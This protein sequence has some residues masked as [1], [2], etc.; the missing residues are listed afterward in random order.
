[1]G[2]SD[3]KQKYYDNLEA[4]EK[5]E[6]RWSQLES[7]LRRLLSRLSFVGEG[8]SEKLDL[9]L[10]QLRNKVRSENLAPLQ[11]LIDGVVKLAESQSGDETG[12]DEAK[13]RQVMVGL[14]KQADFQKPFIKRSTA[15]NRRLA[16]ESFSVE[17][18]S[19]FGGL[20]IDHLKA[21]GES[22]DQPTSSVLGR[23][24]KKDVSEAA[25]VSESRPEAPSLENE[26]QA[27]DV[28]LFLLDSLSTSGIS[29]VELDLLRREVEGAKTRREFEQL[30]RQLGNLITP[31][32]GARPEPEEVLLKL[33]ETLELPADSQEE[34]SVLQ[35]KLRRGVADSELFS[36]TEQ[37]ASLV[38][39]LREKAESEREAVERFLLQLSEQLQYLDS[40]LND[41]GREGGEIFSDSRSMNEE[42]NSHVSGL[43][44]SV[45]A[46]T[47]LSELKLT[48]TESLSNLQEHM[49]KHREE[50]DGR[51]EQFKGNI[52]GLKVKLEE[53]EQNSSELKKQVRDAREEAYIDALTGVNNRHGF[54][55]KMEQE[56]NR[57]QRYEYPMSL[58]MLD[59][60][61]FKKV[62]DTYGHQAGDKVLGVLGQLLK[63]QT[64]E[65]DLVGRYG[66]E[67]FVVL[68]PE[69]GRTSA[70]G[71][72]EKIR[73]TVEK[74][75][76]H[77]EGSRVPLT[78]SC[79]VASFEKD[80][81]P[82]DVIKRADKALYEAKSSG[83]N[84]S[85]VA[86]P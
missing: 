83:R 85:E 35:A 68:L 5:N 44:A 24:F 73:Q 39:Q 19:D 74:M 51:V 61:F 26:I 38:G 12:L 4:L 55:V 36:I 53:M 9:R 45:A 11:K 41:I 17:L 84:R 8:R 14:L 18:L 78:L 49:R 72:A 56:F 25:P 67:E 15:I 31:E 6:E 37:I 7:G 60:D 27:L 10:E 76:F 69:T 65:V 86:I 48:I 50:E 21:S 43:H 42:V 58:I 54:D 40:E 29:R 64:R 16:K 75:G 59:I 20:F 71:V 3:W 52:K 32:G 46:A 82:M 80:E 33:M 1:M 81:K 66:G 62:N 57:W 30:A 63:K 47:D 2:N 79:G 28:F 23:L 13:L 22:G 77:S 70:H 34:A